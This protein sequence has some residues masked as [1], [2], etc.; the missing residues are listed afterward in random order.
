MHLVV[1]EKN[2]CYSHSLTKSFV[3]FNK[4]NQFSGL[5]PKFKLV[6]GEFFKY[7][8]ILPKGDFHHFQYIKK[9][10]QSKVACTR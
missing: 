8:L 10:P 6:S 5:Q 4:M 7:M 1:N 2:E 9:L 3:L